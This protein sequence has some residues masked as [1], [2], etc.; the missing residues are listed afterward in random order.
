[1]LEHMIGLPDFAVKHLACSLSIPILSFVPNKRRRF[2]RNSHKLIDMTKQ[3]FIA[4][5]AAILTLLPGETSAK[6][7]IVNYTEVRN[8]FHINGTTLPFNVSVS[9]FTYCPQK[10][11]QG[12]LAQL[13]YSFVEGCQRSGNRFL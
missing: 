2:F 7:K 6:E 12:I 9:A 8:Y 1:M 11:E 3:T 5:L 4:L 13:C 10:T